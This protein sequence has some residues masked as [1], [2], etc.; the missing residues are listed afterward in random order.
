M[1]A[2]VAHVGLMSRASYLPRAPFELSLSELLD[3]W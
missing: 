3:V 2:Q 1:L